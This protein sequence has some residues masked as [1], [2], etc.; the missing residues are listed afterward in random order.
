MILIVGANSNLAK[1]IAS[2][3]SEEVLTF[4]RNEYQD[5]H[6]D[7]ASG[8]IRDFFCKEENRISKVFVTAGI[9]DPTIDA[10]KIKEVNLDLPLQI[11]RVASD[12]GIRTITFGTVAETFSGLPNQYVASKVALS[13]EMSRNGYFDTLAHHFRLHTLFGGSTIKKHMFLGQIIESILDNKEFCMSAG[14]QIREYHH[15]D[16]VAKII[17]DIDLNGSIGNFHI[18]HGKPHRLVDVA[19]SVFSKYG[20]LSKLRVGKLEI[21]QAENFESRFI[22]WPSSA[23]YSVRSSLE[24]IGKYVESQ[25]E[26]GRKVV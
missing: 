1:S 8:K 10:R 20:D 24:E 16:D 2:V 11:A 9:T 15:V 18:S 13:N 23:E 25:I 12:L 7:S 4:S 22:P 14:N 5:W 26:K 6:D 3:T 19:L 17:N 21:D